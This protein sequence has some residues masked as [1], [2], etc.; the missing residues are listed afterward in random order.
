LSGF[1]APDSGM[2]RVGAHAEFAFVMDNYDGKYGVRVKLKPV[3]SPG[4]PDTLRIV[5]GLNGKTL[6]SFTLSEPGA[7][8]YTVPLPRNSWT[9]RNSISF[10]LPDATSRQ[11]SEVRAAAAGVAVEWLE[12]VPEGPVSAP[13]PEPH[14]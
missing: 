1:S 8:I 3:L 11:G 9:S 10:D 6:G 12:L 7:R 5:L 2:R 13:S 4:N 14:P